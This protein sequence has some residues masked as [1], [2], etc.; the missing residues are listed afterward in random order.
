MGHSHQEVANS[1]LNTI[2]VLMAALPTCMACNGTELPR[3]AAHLASR[4]L[5]PLF[6]Y[7]QGPFIIVVGPFK[8]KLGPKA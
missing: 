7:W 5:W 4:K 3:K 6:L 1:T 2:G 8:S